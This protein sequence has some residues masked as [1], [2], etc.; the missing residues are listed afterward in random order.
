MIGG[1]ELYA[2]TLPLAARLH[3][4][5]VDTVVADADAFFP[6]F[7]T[8]R[9]REVARETH[10]VDPRHAAAFDFVDYVAV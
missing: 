2:L 7:E 5:H 1:G 8:T 4:T 6:A 10:P 9:W 3:L